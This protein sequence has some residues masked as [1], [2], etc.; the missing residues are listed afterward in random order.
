M[1]NNNYN[2][3]K[4]KIKNLQNSIVQRAI[5]RDNYI[6]NDAMNY[7]D[8]IYKYS[9]QNGNDEEVKE[10]FKI[11]DVILLSNLHYIR[12][13][14]NAYIHNDD[15]SNIDYKKILNILNDYQKYI[16]RNSTN[17]NIP[18]FDFENEI[19]IKQLYQSN[20]ENN[21][22][23]QENE[24]DVYY[25]SCYHPNGKMLKLERH[26]NNTE[27][28]NLS[29]FAV[30]HN[31]LIRTRM[32][33]KT[34]YLLQMNL[35][36]QELNTVYYFQM[37]ILNAIKSG[38]FLINQKNKIAINKKSMEYVKI[39]L[40][41]LNYYINLFNHLMK[42]KVEELKYTI[43]ENYEKGININE[44][45]FSF[46]IVDEQLN[47]IQPIWISKRMEYTFSQENKKHYEKLLYEIFKYKEFRK[48]QLE[49]ISNI[50]QS[51]NE[52]VNIAILPTGY[53]KSLIYQ[54]MAM[55][56]PMK[57]IIISPTEIL[58]YDQITNLHENEIDL[59]S[60]LDK[61][62]TTR[63]SIINYS[64][65]ETF[66]HERMLNYLEKLD[67][68]N[69]IFNIVL[70]E[71][72]YI[73]VWGHSFNPT[74]LSLSKVIVE[75]IKNAQITMFTA[76]AS[77]VVLR[78][79]KLQFK[80]KEIKI[81]SPVSMNR[82]NIQYNIINGDNIDSLVEN[83]IKVFE[84][85]YE[86]DSLCDC[87]TKIQPNLT[88]I[89]NNDPKVLKEMYKQF[90]KSEKIK[91][92]VILWD[93]T[94]QTY[95]LFRHGIKTILLANDDFVVGINIPNLRNI[96][97]IGIPPSKEW[98]YQEGGRVGRS[99]GE[100]NIIIGYM[101]HKEK[102]IDNIFDLNIPVNEI[103]STI[104]NNNEYIDIANK[105]YILNYLK[106]EEEELK[107]FGVLYNGICKNIYGDLDSSIVIISL[108]TKAKKEYNF[109]I[110]ILFLISFID[111][112]L[113]TDSKSPIK[114]DYII[115][116]KLL[117][118]NLHFYDLNDY[119]AKAIQKILEINMKDNDK[120]IDQISQANDME[121]IVRGMIEWI[122]ENILFQKRQMLINTYQLL[123]DF[124]GDSSV[125]EENLATHFNIK[126]YN[127]GLESIRNTEDT[128]K[129]HKSKEITNLELTD[130]MNDRKSVINKITQKKEKAREDYIIEKAY[131][132]QEM[133]VTA[134]DIVDNIEEL[135]NS[136]MMK[137]KC[138][139]LIEETY[140]F[141]LLLILAILEL[142]KNGSKMIRFKT[143]A[144]NLKEKDLLKLYM[145][146]KEN[147]TK[148]NIKR[149]RKIIKE[150]YPAK[151]LIRSIKYF[152]L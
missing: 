77:N 63:E 60:V 128:T 71:C 6:V 114:R 89:I 80:K 148:R 54:F 103:L 107:A 94:R 7:I 81:M 86:T 52:Q 46:E 4:I 139:K 84:N 19:N 51:T 88:L 124:D 142:Q 10:W 146:E 42:E 136:E 101:K 15:S 76:T 121:D 104:K 29:V 133:D 145:L 96:I 132:I 16:K 130:D 36:E 98:L 41:N 120:L 131:P 118:K 24:T 85:S 20:H 26:Y 65:T 53:G 45:I 126:I 113:Y 122:H 119:I 151:G 49:I 87:S 99:E 44:K 134:W 5:I 48:G 2:Q 67:Q 152:F 23:S 97:C 68:N 123:E 102:V 18:F 61:N 59:V 57:T 105:N 83:I 144:Q 21:I 31:L 140:S 32:I 34:D 93:N 12:N 143:L 137:V 14:R 30:I 129:K 100:S 78:D 40:N 111:I 92:Y 33:P 115:T 56:Q 117:C 135:E 74:Y 27:N 28:G 150:V 62:R 127:P 38:E 11:K 50:V 82:G 39:A 108:D 70:D 17:Y 90:Y 58:L 47:Y 8:L 116:Y 66:L 79:I 72:H 35:S 1:E 75:K 149:A 9:F 110:Y 112:W 55:L 138:E 141:G 43:V 147:M 25:Y 91:D 109:V 69:E 125:L 22:E 106:D 37:I 64:T 73:S 13:Q 95:E 3:I